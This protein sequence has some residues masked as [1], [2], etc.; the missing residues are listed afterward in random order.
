MPINNE[1]DIV[2]LPTDLGIGDEVK[3]E[4]VDHLDSID[5]KLVSSP[6]IE[7]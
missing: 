3:T 4:Y 6:P 1:L 7:E 5:V 2:S